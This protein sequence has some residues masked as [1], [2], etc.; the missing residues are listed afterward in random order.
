MRMLVSAA[1]RPVF[2]RVLGDELA[3]ER[4]LE[5]RANSGIVGSQ[6]LLRQSKPGPE[7]T[8]S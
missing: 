4:A 7:E 2:A 8:T 6:R 5:D 3:A 1:H